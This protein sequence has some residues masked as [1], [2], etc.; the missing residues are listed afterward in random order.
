MDYL[1]FD[2]LAVGLPSLVLLHGLPGRRVL[3]VPVLVLATVALLWTAPWDD[4]LV[5]SGVWSYDP[6]AVL[7]RLG[8]VPVEE[9]V[10][11]ALEVLL[12]GAWALRAGTL[13]TASTS[14]RTG[15]SL[16]PNRSGARSRGG[17]LWALVALVGLLLLLA[18]GHARYLG[19]LLVWAAPPLA[20]QHLVAGDVLADRRVARLRTA[21]P[22]AL[23]LCVADRVALAQGTWSITP[24]SATGAGVLGL[25]VEELLF[26]ALT[27]LLVTDGL[28]LAADPAVRRRLAWLTAPRD[29]RPTAR[30]SGAALPLTR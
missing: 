30:S 17:A 27:C 12:V 11:V 16:R 4:H 14:A 13:T 29:R 15:S 24:S 20:L 21:A 5:R 10:F 6:S 9:Y 23:W 22:V 3:V 7:G 26:F 1:L 25:P 8:A 18:G 2:V 19:L 28:L